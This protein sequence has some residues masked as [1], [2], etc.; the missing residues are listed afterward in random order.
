MVIDID[1]T[2]LSV[3]TLSMKPSILF[4]AKNFS[5]NHFLNSHITQREFIHL[6]ES[7]LKRMKDYNDQLI[8]ISEIIRL[9]KEYVNNSEIKLSRLEENDLTKNGTKFWEN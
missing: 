4:G 5:N 3:N 2:L 7:H 8:F 1:Y 9:G 6:I